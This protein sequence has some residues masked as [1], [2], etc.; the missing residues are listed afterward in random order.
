MEKR[1]EDFILSVQQLADIRNLDTFNPIVFQMEHP[2]TAT[3]YTIVGAKIEPSYLGLPINVTWVVLDPSDDYYLQALKLKTERDDETVTNKPK[4]EGADAYWHVVRS[5]DEIFAD[6]Q[7]YVQVQ[8]LIGPAGPVGPTGPQ[9]TNGTSGTVDM[10]AFL[11]QALAKLTELSG[12]L[13]IRGSSAV[14]A[15]GTSQYE[16][17]LT[18]PSVG[19]DGT[20]TDTTRQVYSPIYATPATA[21]PLPANTSISI[22]GKLTAGSTSVDVGVKLIATYPSWTK[23]AQAEKTVTITSKTVSGIT[24]TG[25]ASVYAGSSSTYTVSATYSDGSTASITPTWTL[26]ASTYAS[27]STAGTMTALNPLT[28]DQSVTL[29]ATYNGLTATKTVSLKQLLATTLTINGVAALSGA[30][31]QTYTANVT[32]NSGAT[33]TVTPTWS[34][35]STAHASITAGGVVT[36]DNTS[37]T[38]NVLASYLVPGTT[39]PVTASKGITVT[40]LVTP[41]YPYYGTGPALPADWQAFITALPYRGTA[42]SVNV[43]MSYD[44]IGTTV[45]GYFAYPKSYGKAQFFDKL[46]QFTGG[47][48]GAGNSTQGPST[49][50]I[51][52]SNDE[53]FETN[54]VINGVSTA[55]YVYRTDYANL[56]S[57]SDNKW[58]VSPAA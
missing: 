32:Y 11:G 20:I 8:G 51:N 21:T 27:I 15:A 41:I 48:G 43:D 28:A 14:P 30:V 55:F 1:L 37:S 34:L 39:T 19:T 2:L 16:L 42:A 6:P 10:D 47:W 56:G 29:T 49:A 24:I 18:E 52:A 45:Y 31:S 13:E 26:S 25:A 44:C 17:W 35:S 50:S 54:V 38:F 46:S 33:A 5:Y 40:A 53:P 23:V 22:D 57:A 12:T 36:T 9:G 58:L 4:V 3:R 7:Y